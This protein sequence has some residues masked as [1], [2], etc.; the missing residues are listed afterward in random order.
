MRK[1][2][3]SEQAY[4]IIKNKIIFGEL[5]FGEEIDQKML[6]QSLGFNSVTPVREALLLLQNEKLVTI[7]P[8]K[9]MYISEVSIDEVLENYQ[10]R[11]IIEPTVFAVTAPDVLPERIKEYQSMFCHYIRQAEQHK[12]SLREYLQVDMDFHLELLKPIGNR[13]LESIMKGIYEQNARYRM[14]CLKLRNPERMLQEHLDILSAL[15][16]RDTKHAVQALKTHI[17]N[18]KKPFITGTHQFL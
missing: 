16:K 10:L 18:S 5:T 3:L 15:E 17:L 1:Q 14:V 9:G 13:N 8:R 7:I 6:A 4:D 12:L 11:E 2:T